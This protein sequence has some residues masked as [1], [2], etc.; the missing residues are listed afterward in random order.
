MRVPTTRPLQDYVDADHQSESKDGSLNRRVLGIPS[1]DPSRSGLFLKLLKAQSRDRSSLSGV[2]AWR[3]T[4]TQSSLMADADA[5][6]VRRV[7][8]PRVVATWSGRGEG[9]DG[10][11][12]LSVPGEFD[13]LLESDRHGVSDIDG[14]HISPA[15]SDLVERIGDRDPLVVND[16]LGS[17]EDQV[18][19]GQEQSRPKRSG[20]ST[21]ERE[22]TEALVGVDHRSDRSESEEY[23]TAS[24]T[25]D[26]GV[27]HG[28]ILSR[29]VMVT[30]E[31]TGGVT[32]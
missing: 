12:G 23:V 14:D 2:T 11:S 30:F 7:Y 31:S 29:A 5:A 28:A 20:D 17:N 19:N 25:E 26:F 9:V 13:C 10:L 6:K 16:Y 15:S 4:G 22:V 21:C 18:G 32:R 1:L 3:V 24:R 27:G 8:G